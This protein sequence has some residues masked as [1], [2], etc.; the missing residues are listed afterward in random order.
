MLTTLEPFHQPTGTHME[1]QGKTALI[2]GGSSGIGLAT[3]RHFVAAGARVTITGQDE[4]RLAEAAQSLGPNVRALRADVRQLADLSSLA[5][6]VSADRQPLDVLFV[7]AGVAFA[8]PLGTVDEARYAD[9]FD[10]NVRGAFFT[11]QALAPHMAR[12]GSIILNT[13][14]LNQVGT[15]GLSL[16]SASKAAVRSLTRTLAAEL[17]PTGLRVNAVSPGAIDTPI[18]GKTG[19]APEA[20]AAFAQRI[21]AGVP[22]GRFGKAEEVAAAAIF[23]AS[24]ASS[25]MLGA[26]I[27]VDGGLSQL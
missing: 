26:E 12:G 16:L 1:L 22:M 3:A 8:T 25:Y 27:V 20:L 9:V 2:T 21:E 24:D 18:H 17:W 13:S 6:Q 15:P 14:W 10:V 19:M 11:V 23:L 7:N 4:T 5:Q